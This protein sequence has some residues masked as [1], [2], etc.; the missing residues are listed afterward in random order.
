MQTAQTKDPLTQTIRVGFDLDG[1]L[2]Y[3]P[4]RIIRPIISLIKHIFSKRKRLSFYYPKSPFKQWLWRLFHKSSIF[5]APGI[6]DIRELVRHKKIEAYIITARYSFLGKEL[7]EWIKKNKFDTVFAAVYYNKE[8]EQPH[9]FKERMIKKLNLQVFVEDN[10]DIVDHLSKKK[11]A[12][13]LWIYNIFDRGIAYPH[14]FGYLKKAVDSIK[15]MSSSSIVG[16]F[17]KSATP[18][19]KAGMSLSC[20]SAS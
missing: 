8:D 13:I 5:I 19:A 9:L 4:A 15:E 2:L 7:T 1:V 10:Y 18:S 3:N 16:A 6:G 11:L 17:R 20:S 12:R 14:K